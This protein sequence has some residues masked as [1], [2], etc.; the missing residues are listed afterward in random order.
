MAKGMAAQRLILVPGKPTRVT[1]LE[2]VQVNLKNVRQVRKVLVADLHVVR[3]L[4]FD[5]NTLRR[6]TPG[7][8]A[9][10]DDVG[11]YER[12]VFH[13]RLGGQKAVHIATSGCEWASLSGGPAGW[14]TDKLTHDVRTA[15]R[16][17]SSHRS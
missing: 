5:L 6:V 14:V 2:Y 11:G 12:L 1:I 16:M 8:H 7:T 3:R 15:L 9:C 10:P 13:Y 17:R 4:Q